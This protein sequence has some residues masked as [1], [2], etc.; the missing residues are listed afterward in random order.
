[1]RMKQLV[2]GLGGIFCLLAV[3]AS[4]AGEIQVGG[5]WIR[6]APPTAK[7]LAAY[8]V[9]SNASQEPVK[10]VSVDSP[11]FSAVEV[12][13][14]MVHQGRMHMMAVEN[15]EIAPGKSLTLNPGGYHLMLMDPRKMLKSG[16]RVLLRLQFDTGEALSVNAV[17][18][19]HPVP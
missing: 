14:S 12:H 9:I 8:M 5:A 19:K 4:W 6:S 11:D 13:Q 18:K 3:Q 10:L 1:M 2:R 15:L 17:V 16:D 7:A